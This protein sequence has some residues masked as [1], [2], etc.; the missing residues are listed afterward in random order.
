VIVGGYC[1]AH[2]HDFTR[3]PPR[4]L[5]Q[6]VVQSRERPEPELV[7]TRLSERELAAERSRKR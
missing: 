7:I 2:R 3:Q 6:H 5:A 1:N 4:V